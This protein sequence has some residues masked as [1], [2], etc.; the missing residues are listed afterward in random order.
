MFYLTEHLS[1]EG[2][3][4]RWKQVIKI[5]KI[6]EW[7]RPEVEE[8]LTATRQLSEPLKQGGDSPLVLHNQH[9]LINP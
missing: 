3:V 6:K 5:T 4:D 1:K 2:G 9:K 7:E 8:N